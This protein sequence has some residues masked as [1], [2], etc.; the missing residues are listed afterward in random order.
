MVKELAE[1]K[2][3][4]ETLKAKDQ[5]LWVQRTNTVWETA[6]EIVNNELIYA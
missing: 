1:K 3:I 2:G 5:M 4:T 6:T